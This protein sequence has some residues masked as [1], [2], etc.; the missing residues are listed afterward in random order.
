MHQLNGFYVLRQPVQ[1]VGVSNN[2]V[3]GHAIREAAGNK[4]IKHLTT[5]LL[6]LWYKKSGQPNCPDSARILRK[7]QSAQKL[8]QDL[9]TSPNLRKYTNLVYFLLTIPQIGV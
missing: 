5:F 9:C 4:A 6:P 7:W 3:P 8:P 2:D 1:I